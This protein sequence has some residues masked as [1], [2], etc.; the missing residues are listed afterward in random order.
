MP[1]SFSE[2]TVFAEQLVSLASGNI[3]LVVFDSMTSLYR[4]ELATTKEVFRANREL[5]RQLGFIK[6]AAASHGFPALI[7]SQVYS[8]VDAEEPSVIPVSSRLL[9]YW[10]DIVLR[11]D[12]ASPTGVRMACLEKPRR[13]PTRWMF[14]IGA[15]GLIDLGLA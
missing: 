15:T 14:R 3:K 12:P 2:Q 7:L 6:E 9:S 10:S 13:S 4:E 5:N 11:L 1:S 8:V